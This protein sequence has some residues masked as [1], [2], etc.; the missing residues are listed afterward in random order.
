MQL[1]HYNKTTKAASMGLQDSSGENG[2]SSLHS[3]KEKKK[4]QP[5]TVSFPYDFLPL[6]TLIFSYYAVFC[7]RL[8]PS[9][10]T[11]TGLQHLILFLSC[12]K[13]WVWE[14]PLIFFC[15]SLD[16]SENRTINNWSGLASLPL[17]LNYCQVKFNSN[18]MRVRSSRATFL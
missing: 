17:P 1:F 15:T 16:N 7:F 6:F 11:F 4:Q 10:T 12:H 18:E 2:K 8:S 9:T 5:H 14:T 3:L 13:M